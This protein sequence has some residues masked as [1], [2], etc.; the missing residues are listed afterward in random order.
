MASQKRLYLIDGMALIYRAH[1]ALIKQPLM[2]SDGRHTSAIFGFMNM[3]ERLIRERSPDMLAVILDSKQPTFRH[4]IYTEYKAT[5]EK[6]PDELTEQL[7]P[8][9]EVIKATRIPIV[10]HPGFEADDIIGTLAKQ[11]DNDGLR[12]YIVSGDKDLMQLITDNVF[13]FTPGSRWKPDTIYDHKAVVEKWGVPPDKIIDFLALTGDISDNVPGIRG[14]GPKTAKKLID[15]FKNLDKLL[16]NAEDISNIKLRDKVMQNKDL[17]LLSKELVTIH[18]D[19]PVELHIQDFE[20]QPMD[21]PKLTKLL[22][23]LELTS[24]LNRIDKFNG[25]ATPDIAEDI[26]KNYTTVTSHEELD[27]LCKEL[28]EAEIISFD[29]ETTSTD[30]NRGELVGMSFS[31]KENTGW[32]IP[33]KC[34]DITNQ[35]NLSLKEILEKLRPIFEGESHRICGQ[36]IKYDALVLRKYGIHLNGIEF[37][38]M[39]AAHLIRPDLTSLKMDTLSQLYLSY[40]MRPIEELIGTG[41][42]Q[43]TMDEVPLNDVSFYAAEDADVALQLTNILGGFL[44]EEELELPFRKVEIPLIPVLIKMESNGVY[45]D[46]DFLS[47]LSNE[48]GGKME[49]IKEDIYTSAGKEFN[50]NSP[51]QL[52]EIL[53]D[54]LGLKTVRKRSTD[55]NVLEVLKNHHPLPKMVLDYRKYMKLT[56]T[57]IDAFPNFVHPDTGRVHTSLNQTIAATGR[58]SSTRPNFQ[59]IPIRTEIGREIRKAFTTQAPGWS[60]CSMDYSQIELRIMAHLADESA[61]INAFENEEDIHARTA[62]LVFDTPVEEVTPDQRRSAKV[63]NFGIMYGAGPYRMSQE[64]SISMADAKELINTYFTT[65]PGIRKFIDNTIISAKQKGFVSTLMGRKR[66]TPNLR[67]KRQQVAQAEER[68]AINMPIQGTAAELI[69]IAM[70]NIH[71]EMKDRSMKSKMILQIHDELLFEAP[72]NEIDELTAL[73]SQKMETALELSVPLKV[74]TGIGVN[75][76]DAH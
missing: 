40:R 63:V 75:W 64:L 46:L 39:I 29:T 58:L 61:L 51:K 54:D 10:Q 53:F 20:R 28:L 34:P 6:M 12:T 33:V 3:M 31:T 62:S 60:I 35:S 26:D 50:I 14:I 73:V 38:T 56:S 72:N 30:P 25:T 15:Q 43:K 69:K 68:A 66:K 13:L 59:N 2:T 45:L 4:D 1:F 5:R 21:T 9:F 24:I 23:D 57:Y 67:S 27:N 8:L 70:I 42:S 65:Y 76:Y 47:D 71:Q 44:K 17:A 48:F 32:Y 55:V 7:E 16:E 41:S 11:A 22:Q 18:L 19:V 74:D 52:G 36:N 49:S 37:D